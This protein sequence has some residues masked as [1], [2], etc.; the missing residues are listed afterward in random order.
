MAFALLTAYNVIIVRFNLAAMV[1]AR[2]DTFQYAGFQRCVGAF[3]DHGKAL[4]IPPSFYCMA[5][6]AETGQEFLP[7]F[8]GLWIR[9]ALAGANLQGWRDREGGNRRGRGRE[10]RP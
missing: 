7:G 8:M 3:V 9:G 4:I 6:D 5:E 1:Q 10:D 2:H